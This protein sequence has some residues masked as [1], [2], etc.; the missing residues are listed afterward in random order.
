MNPDPVVRRSALD[1]LCHRYMPALRAHLVRQK[2]LPPEEADDVLQGFITGKILEQGILQRVRPERGRFRNFLLVS[3]NRYLVSRV[4]HDN[5]QKRRANAPDISLEPQ[6]DTT[7]PESGEAFSMEWARQLVA[8]ALRR[9]REDCQSPQRQSMWII[10]E[11]RVLEPTLLGAKPG[12]YDELVRRFD[13]KSPREAQNVLVNAK[14]RF[15][16]CLRDAITDYEGPQA[17]IDAEIQDL[18]RILSKGV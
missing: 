8:D 7:A 2:R 1:Q 12:D 17:D 4:R 14:R 9:M 6:L 18:Q 5:A 16:Q 13:F 3:L 15:I 11:Q 10:F